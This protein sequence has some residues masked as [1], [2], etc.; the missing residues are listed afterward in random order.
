[1]YPCLSFRSHSAC[2]VIPRK[3]PTVKSSIIQSCFILSDKSIRTQR[4]ASLPSHPAPSSS[5][6]RHHSHLSTYRTCLAQT[7]RH[8]NYINI[9]PW[10]ASHIPPPPGAH[11]E[12]FRK[13]SALPVATRAGLDAASGTAPVVLCENRAK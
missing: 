1:M 7:M 13:H 11:L 9:H 5:S 8:W 6:C 3:L 12:V 10:A 2:F 4:T